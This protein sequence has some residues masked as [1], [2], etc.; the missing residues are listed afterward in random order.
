MHLVDNVRTDYVHSSSLLQSTHQD[1]GTDI[2]V[3]VAVGVV[4]V[5]FS[6]FLLLFL[7]WKHIISNIL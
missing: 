4:V 2:V 6:F 1:W 3:V 5:F 7:F